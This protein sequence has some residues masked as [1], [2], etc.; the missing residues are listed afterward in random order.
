MKIGID[1]DCTPEEARAFLGLPE[2]APLQRAVMA[3]IE[4][5][6]LRGVEAMEPEKL[7]EVWLPAGVK[8]WEQ[9]QK[10]WSELAGAAQGRE[11]P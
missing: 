11:K 9:M 8:G 2:V 4:E 5:Q 6:M 3:K 1:I 7:L 10:F